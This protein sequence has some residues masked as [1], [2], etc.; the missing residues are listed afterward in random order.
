M[1]KNFLLINGIVDVVTTLIKAFVALWITYMI[2]TSVVQLSDSYYE[3]KKD[4]QCSET[5]AESCE[6]ID[7]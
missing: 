7:Q 6:Q 2:C 5:V 1:N 3:N 4:C